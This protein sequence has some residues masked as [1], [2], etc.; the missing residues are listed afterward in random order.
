MNIERMINANIFNSTPLVNT[1]WLVQI[2]S[3]IR[4]SGSAA[5]RDDGW[6]GLF[7][8]RLVSGVF[9]FDLPLFFQAVFRLFLLF[10]AAFIFFSFFAHNYSSVDLFELASVW[11]AGWCNID[12][13]LTAMHPAGHPVECW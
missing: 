4:G 9:L 3:I 10:L 13:N 12:V 6:I 2:L 5:P 7:G 1:K 11:D 8:V